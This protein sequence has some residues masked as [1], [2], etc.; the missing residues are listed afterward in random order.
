MQRSITVISRTGLAIA[1]MLALGPAAAIAQTA[2]DAHWNEWVGCWD[3]VGDGSTTRLTPPEEAA[4]GAGPIRPGASRNARVCVAPSQGGAELRTMVG[5]QQVM[6]QTIIADGRDHAI[7]DGGCTGTQRAQWS[8]DGL[9]LFSRAQVTCDAQAPRTVSGLALMG[10]DAQWVDVQAVTVEGRDSVRVRRFRPAADR[11]R[12]RTAPLAAAV[13][14]RTEHIKEASA[15][16]APR[17]LEAALIETGARFD[18]SS[19]TLLDLNKAGVADSVTDL[20]VALSYPQAFA[21]RSAGPD[22][23]LAPPPP[24]YPDFVDASFENPFFYSPYYSNYY[25]S[26][27]FFSPFG[28]SY[29]WLYPQFGAPGVIVIPGDGG[30]GLPG[31]GLPENGKAVNGLGYT[32]V[33]P[34]DR[35]STAEGSGEATPR[36]NGSSRGSVTPRGYTAGDTSSGSSSSSS[37]GS[38]SSGSSG[39]SSAGSSGGSSGGSSDGGGRTAVPR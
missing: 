34:R 15:L 36:S 29:L 4:A 21:V 11:V 13:R 20:M 5:D 30:G 7:S 17:A 3:L 32:R 1:S 39:G 33:Y 10:P 25:Y 19:K 23:R 18:L 37:G 27:Y 12:V 8:A 28:Y 31:N 16:V 9:R 22:D 6:T 14:L 2:P 38:S 26:P 35:A 24:L